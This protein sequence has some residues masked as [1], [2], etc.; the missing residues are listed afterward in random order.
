[1]HAIHPNQ[2]DQLPLEGF[3][4]SYETYGDPQAPPVALLPTWPEASVSKVKVCF[5]ALP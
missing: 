4:I 3:K 1:M 5:E 2:F